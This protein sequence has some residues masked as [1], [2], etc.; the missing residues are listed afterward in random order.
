MENF[1]KILKALRKAAGISQR[2]M[3]AQAGIDHTY[4][5]KIEN[6][7]YAP[8]SEE[9]L[10]KIAEALKVDKD[11]LILVAG[12]IPSDIKNDLLALSYEQFCK[13]RKIVERMR[14][15]AE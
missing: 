10:I 12:K 6:G 7:V 2:N 5:S 3:A 11:S 15:D 14:R 13:V 8:P 1:G 4:L 9:S